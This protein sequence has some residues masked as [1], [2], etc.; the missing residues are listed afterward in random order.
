MYKNKIFKNILKFLADEINK[1]FRVNS[2][3]INMF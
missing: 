2:I 3:K 1:M